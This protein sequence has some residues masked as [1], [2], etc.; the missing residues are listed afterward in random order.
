MTRQSTSKQAE[1]VILVAPSVEAITSAAS[2][3]LKLP[4][5]SIRR[6]VLLT[7]VRGHPL[8]TALPASGDCNG[9]L[10]NDALLWV[11]TSDGA[12]GA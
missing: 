10:K 7:S 8:G 2:N 11:S 5:K 6:L 9:Y 12:G 3:K 4:A 1:S